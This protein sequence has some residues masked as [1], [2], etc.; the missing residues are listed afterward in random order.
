MQTSVAVTQFAWPP[1][2]GLAPQLAEVA[3]FCDER[4]IDSVFVSDHLVQGIEPGTDPADPM[5]EALTTLGYLAGITERVRLGVLVA[6]VTLRPPA[7]L[8]KA[9]TTLDVLSGGR[10]W[11]G[12]GAGYQVQEGDD[13]GVPLPETAERFEWLEDTLALALQMWDGGESP[14]RGRRLEA[15]GPIGRPVPVSRPHPPVLIG[16]TGERRTLPLVARF[17]DACNLFDVGDGGEEIRHKLAVLARCCDEV[18]RPFDEIT[19]TVSTRLMPEDDAAG[20]VA[21][22]RALRDAGAEHLVVLAA[23]PWT[24]DRLAVLADAADA[25]AEPRS[26]VSEGS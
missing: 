19:A 4:R 21:R 11:F 12:I 9:V 18:G 20:F 16:G 26:F 22:A 6:A 1:E 25:L 15:A 14:Y 23:G 10:A 24:L 5:L 7:L 3:R 13:F 17:G 2:A 8:V